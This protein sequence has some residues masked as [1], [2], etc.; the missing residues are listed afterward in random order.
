[1]DP[2]QNVCNVVDPSLLHIQDLRGPVQIHH[3]VGRL[4]Q[5]VQ[6]ALGGQVQGSVVA[7]VL[8]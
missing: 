4:G 1:M 5:Q 3:A 7:R 6:E 2:L 8:R